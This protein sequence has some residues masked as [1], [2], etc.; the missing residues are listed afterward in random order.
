MIALPLVLSVSILFAF[1]AALSTPHLAGRWSPLDR[2]I[3][4]FVLACCQII[5]TEILLGWLGLLHRWP[6]VALNLAASGVL[7]GLGR[8]ALPALAGEWAAVMRST[9]RVVRAH[10][11]MALMAGWLASI[12]LYIA[13]ANWLLPPTDWDSLRYHL[14]IAAQMIQN[15]GIGEVT[16]DTVFINTYPKNFELVFLWWMLLSGGDQW[17]NATQIPFFGVA[18]V[19]TYRLARLTNLSRHHSLFGALLLGG[20]P[21]VLQQLMSTMVDVMFATL[22]LAAAWGF[23]R[24]VLNGIVADLLLSG[25]AAG[26]A[27][28][29]K[30]NGVTVPAVLGLLV[31]V[32]ALRRWRS[33]P[34]HPWLPP[35][36]W[37]AV[38]AF[39]LSFHWYAKNWWVYGN[40]IEP[41]Q[42][43]VLGHEVFKGSV[44]SYEYLVSEKLDN[45]SPRVIENLPEERPPRHAIEGLW[46]AWHEP[47]FLFSSFGKLG[48]LG[49][50]WL[51]LLLPAL[52]T[53]AVL[54]WL[55][56]RRTLWWLYGALLP[57]YLLFL[58]HQW[59]T[60]YG[61]FI[62]ALGSV[63]FVV[64]LD[65]FPRLARPLR[66]VALALFLFSSAH[67]TLN[68]EATPGRLRALLNVP[69]GERIAQVE[70]PYSVNH[71]TRE[72]ARW[73]RQQD[74]AGTVLRYHTREWHFTYPLWNHEFSNRVEFLP[75]AADSGQWRLQ[76]AGADWLLVS[77]GSREAAWTE[78]LG[79]YRKAYDDDSFAVYRH[80]L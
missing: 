55:S 31:L 60:R 3:A 6:L 76:A 42:L 52:P 10:P 38:P 59:I 65:G 17:V 74:T 15:H 2:L 32:V 43:S 41:F 12:L 48:G 18:M 37:F 30:G 80:A 64:L 62:L 19:I 73:W 72:L 67:G 69:H 27:A 5:V 79:T 47:L 40:P 61:I 75:P 25:I 44:D 77:A 36:L 71:G 57:P 9:W 21:V 68:K 4:S 26:L 78:A 54:A 46:Y 70:G 51:I 39:L 16:T 20:A 63:A 49:S 58:T 56:G 29:G 35:I 22:T 14:P 33:S 50:T 1:L 11:G 45:L 53:A 13:G 66:T 7:L 23:Y 24:Y 28:G 8:P 34:A